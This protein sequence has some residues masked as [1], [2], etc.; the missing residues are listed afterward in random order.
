M[1]SIKSG[2]DFALKD[3]ADLLD[4][5]GD[6]EAE[7]CVEDMDGVGDD[8]SRGI[9]LLE[10]LLIRSSLCCSRADVFLLKSEL[11]LD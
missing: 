1:G 11:F 9:L 2:G 5:A 6:D 7:E 8:G 10:A 4:D 3:D